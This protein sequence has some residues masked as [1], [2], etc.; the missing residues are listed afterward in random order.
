MN[1][2]SPDVAK[3]LDCLLFMRSHGPI[4]PDGDGNTVCRRCTTALTKA[5]NLLTKEMKRKDKNG[6]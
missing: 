1:E 3:A 6:K 2:P 5:I 4:G